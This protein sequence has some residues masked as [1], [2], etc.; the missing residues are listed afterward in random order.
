M[1]QLVLLFERQLGSSPTRCGVDEMRVIA[2][3]AAAT[4]RVDDRAVPLAFSDDRLWVASMLHHHQ[5]ASVMS[6][7]IIDSVQCCNELLVVA[8][9]G[10]RLSGVACAVH[11]RCAA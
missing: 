7:A 9:V 5:H 3:A 1:R 4:R 11:T 2:E 10:F 6:M 8:R